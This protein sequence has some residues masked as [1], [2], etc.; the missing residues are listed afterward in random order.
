MWR[1]VTKALE[2]RNR[3][4]EPKEAAKRALSRLVTDASGTVSQAAKRAL[5][6]IEGAEM[7]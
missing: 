5:S 7:G 3:A 1:V 4:A 6:A 2:R